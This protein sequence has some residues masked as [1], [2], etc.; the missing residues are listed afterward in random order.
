[1]TIF[2]AVPL[3]YCE[4]DI[5]CDLIPYAFNSNAAVALGAVAEY[6]QNQL[7]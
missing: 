6:R 3:C 1:M 5:R 4:C 2:I 7:T